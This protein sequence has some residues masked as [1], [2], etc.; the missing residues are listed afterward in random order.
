MSLRPSDHQ[1]QSSP[2]KQSRACTHSRLIS[3][4]VTEDEHQSG[5]VRC[6]ECG[7]I[8]ADPYLKR[9]GKET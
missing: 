1:P 4:S 7:A 6:V 5:K 2:V 8:V 9:D 3:D